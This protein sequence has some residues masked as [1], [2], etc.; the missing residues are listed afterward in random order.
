TADLR[1]IAAAERTGAG[2]SR[3]RW[4]ASV[5]ALSV[6]VIV[7]SSIVAARLLMPHPPAIATV[8]EVNGPVTIE[9]NGDSEAAEKDG[10]LEGGQRIVVPAGASITLKYDD[11]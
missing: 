9:Q 4:T 7:G 6:I 8:T 11:G 2:S 3:W 10:S 5:L 1:S